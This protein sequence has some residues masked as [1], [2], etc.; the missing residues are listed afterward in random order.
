MVVSRLIE[1]PSP[2]KRRRRYRN[3]PDIFGFLHINK[4]LHDLLGDFRRHGFELFE[5]GANLRFDRRGH[6]QL[7]NGIRQ[8]DYD[9]RNVGKAYRATGAKCAEFLVR[10]G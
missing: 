3:V 7:A 2:D 10:N 9:K 8:V 4:W 5:D 1:I 6:G